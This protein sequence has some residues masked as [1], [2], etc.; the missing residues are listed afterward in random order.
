MSRILAID[1]EPDA[2]DLYRRA[3]ASE[4]HQISGVGTGADGLALAAEEEFDAVL[5]DYQLPDTDGIALLPKLL[6]RRP[7]VP[8]IMVTSHGSTSRAVL[9]IR[10]GARDFIEKPFSIDALRVS[11]AN[12]IAFSTLTRR[13]AFHR[14]RA[15]EQYCCDDADQ[16]SPF[17]YLPSTVADVLRKAAPTKAT[18]LLTGET[19]VGKEHAA[20]RIHQASGRTKGAFVAI[21]CAAIPASLAESELFG[22]ERGAFTGATAAAAGKFEVADGGTLFL[23]EIGELPHDL[24]PKLLRVLQEGEI[25]RVG[26][27]ASRKVDVR[28]VAATHRDLEAEV[29]AGRFRQDLFFRINVMHVHLPPLRDDRDSIP[30]LA[31]TFLRRFATV[32]GRRIDGF[33]PDALERLR[34]HDFPGNIRELANAV[35]RAVILEDGPQ[36]RV[37]SLGLTRPGGAPAKTAAPSS[38]IDYRMAREAFEREYFRAVMERAGG[39]QVEA[40][41]LTGLHRNNLRGHLQRLGLL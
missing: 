10:E 5:L 30:T 41:R 13:E 2:R 17:S 9:A 6:A 29:A 37:E 19:G 1:D 35:E 26:A 20:A 39:N 38:E 3:L 33:T 12:A 11:V 16:Q 15:F 23:D 24:Q 28:I 34:A 4:G 32:L 21:N 8:V 40:A 7:D 36:I 14:T 27:R 31:K 25:T 22:H 18:I